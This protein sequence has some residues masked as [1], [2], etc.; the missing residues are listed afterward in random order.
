MERISLL[1]FFIL[2]QKEQMWELIILCCLIVLGIILYRIRTNPC[3]SVVTYAPTGQLGNIL[4]QI[5]ATEGFS[6]LHKIPAELPNHK[7]KHFFRHSTVKRQ[8]NKPQPIHEFSEKD[9]ISF[10]YQDMKPIDERVTYV[11]RGYRQNP[12]YF[13]H[14]RKKILHMFMPPVDVERKMHTMGLDIIVMH[15]RRGDALN[16]PSYH[17][18]GANYY[19]RALN[20][21][22]SRSKVVIVSDDYSWCKTVLIP[23]IPRAQLSPWRSAVDDF[24]L[25]SMARHK[26][27]C[28][29]T[30]SWWAAYLGTEART[31]VCPYPWPKNADSFTIAQDGWI[32]LQITADDEA[33]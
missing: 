21:I 31:V 15:V 25:L 7:Y 13:S 26:V 19:V 1:K 16:H 5:A 29:S 9:D 32:S 22:E 17:N 14:I 12:Q 4:F 6:S 18:L 24:W 33:S 11:I 30:F 8:P 2:I 27:C 3:K 28:S 20:H 23:R 10:Y